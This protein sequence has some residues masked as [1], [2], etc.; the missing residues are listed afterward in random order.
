MRGLPFSVTVRDIQQFFAPLIPINIIIERDEGGRLSGEG[1]VSFGSH[2][3]AFSAMRKDRS[4]I[5]TYIAH[6]CN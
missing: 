6:H 3:D 4:H 5:G 1:E 2:E